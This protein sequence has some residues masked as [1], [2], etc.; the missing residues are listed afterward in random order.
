MPGLHHVELWIADLDEVRAQW[1]WILERVGF[2]LTSEW[3][4]GESWAAGGSYLTLTMSPNLSSSA[5][6]RRR[7]GLNHLAFQGGDRTAVDALMAEA[8]RHGW[9][10]L[11]AGRYP[12]AGG[13]QHYAGWLENASGFKIEVV[14]DPS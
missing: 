13:D 9:R 10:P 8:E 5:H 11:Y 6:D 7:A 4:S 3:S 14:A 1:R 2:S 12:H